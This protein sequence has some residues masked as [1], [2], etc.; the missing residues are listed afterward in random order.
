MPSFQLDSRQRVLTRDGEIV[1]L[2]PKA[3]DLL[4]ALAARPGEVIAKEQLVDAVWPDTHVEEANLSKLIFTIRRE[5]GD[6]V[7]ETVPKRGYRFLGFPS[8]EEAP[9]PVPV[10]A[11]GRRRWWPVAAAAL[12]IVAIGAVWWSRAGVT[13]RPR[14][15]L[16]VIPF[17][18][19]GGTEE[20][21]ARGLSEFIGARLSTMQGMSVLQ[22]VSKNREPRQLARELGATLMLKGTVRRTGERTRVT[23]VL[24]STKD[25]STVGAEALTADS[26]DIFELEE[27]VAARVA[28]LL[29]IQQ[30]LERENDPALK[31]AAQ[32]RAYVS[33]LGLLSR[34]GELEAGQALALLEPLRATDSPLVLSAIGTAHLIRFRENRDLRELDLAESFASRAAKLNRGT[35]RVHA[36]LGSIHRAR[37]AFDRAIVELN[38]AL[39][40]EPDAVDVLL[41]L[42]AVYRRMQRD[43]DAERTFQALIQTHPDCA[44]CLNAYGYFH[45][46]RGRVDEAVKFYARAV[47]LDPENP[48]FLVNLGGQ[49]LKAGRLA[50]AAPLFEKA[51]ALQ[52]APGAY[53]NL[54]YTH[55]LAGDFVRAAEQFEH[56]TRLEPRTFS[57]WG[58]LGDALLMQGN[59]PAAEAAYRRAISIARDE[60]RIDASRS[61]VRAMVAEYLAKTG[62]VD[63]AKVEIERALAATPRDA[64]VLLSA[65]LVEL[66]ARREEAAVALIE[67]ATAAGLSPLIFRDDPQFAPLRT[68]DRFVR[69]VASK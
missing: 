25:Q 50:E 63:T 31:T 68:N 2:T 40:R 17:E 67:R 28:S 46:T 29:H 13:P 26:T 1:R 52:P 59:R 9:V 23:Y 44:L 43:T 5:L 12:L 60:L 19:A 11:V 53:S 69:V 34:D 20:A 24:I 58:N 8:A 48:R 39:E 7:I 64:D 30:S 14:P 65:S 47:A 16:V 21:F 18:A 22:P 35:A 27:R 61:Q 45:S 49:H 33:A 10:P 37:G 54:G 32:Q 51:I 4:A 36:L 57:Y 15:Y 42:A 6:G 41:D 3:F 62:D 56:A 66:H 55:Y 38:A